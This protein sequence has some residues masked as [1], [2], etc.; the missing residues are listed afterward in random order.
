MLEIVKRKGEY[1]YEHT[2]SFERFFEDRLPDRCKSYSSVKD[3]CLSGKD[4]LHVAN[5]SNMFQMKEMGNY[6]DLYLK[7]EVL[8]V[9]GVFEKIISK[10]L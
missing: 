3:E 9:A 8:L 2:N 10:C 7:T 1:P 4:Y 5:V 6:H